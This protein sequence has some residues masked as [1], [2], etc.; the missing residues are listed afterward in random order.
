VGRNVDEE[1]EGPE[2]HDVKELQKQK[3][4]G[5]VEMAALNFNQAGCILTECY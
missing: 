3:T 1:V 5:R 4:K 2:R